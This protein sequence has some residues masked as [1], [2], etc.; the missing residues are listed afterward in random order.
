MNRKRLL[1]R[2]GSLILV[3]VFAASLLLSACT[4]SAPE[5][6]TI[7]ALRPFPW[8][9]PNTINYRELIEVGN[10]MG[11][12]RIVFKDMGGS[13]LY[14]AF[15]QLE[16]VRAGAV[17]LLWSPAAYNISL[18]PEGDIEFLTFGATA[19]DFRE[20]GLLDAMDRMARERIGTA[21][22]GTNTYLIFH[23]FTTKPV[24]KLSDFQGMKLRG[25][26]S[27]NPVMQALGI[28]TVTIAP[29]ELYTALQ[30]GVVDGMSWPS[31]GL[32]GWGFNEVVKYQVYPPFWISDD[33]IEFVRADW[34]DNLPEDARELLL[35]ITLELDRRSYD[36]GMAEHNKEADLL[37]AAGI[38]KAT[39][40]DE[41]WW[42]VQRIEWEEGSKRMRELTPGNAEELI[43]IA[44]QFYPPQE[45]WRT[46]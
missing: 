32:F 39:I 10:Q 43:R 28:S 41:E 24:T 17:D 36:T 34:L 7:R 1:I 22:I 6:I 14:P 3:V 45:V 27:Y 12:G 35:E 15:E 2:F 23:I 5:V 30:T 44:S 20:S 40:S 33:L 11:Q 29:G 21:I 18:F 4:P 25:I 16:A 8:D 31:I 19:M 9:V 38:E 26:S 42:E 37:R 13:E 46:R